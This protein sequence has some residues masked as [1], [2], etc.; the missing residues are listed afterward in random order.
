[1]RSA[2]RMRGSDGWFWV[3]LWYRR[4]AR[5]WFLRWARKEDGEED[6]W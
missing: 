6:N 1:M 5:F 3:E 4:K 2:G